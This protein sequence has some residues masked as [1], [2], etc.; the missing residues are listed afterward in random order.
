MK[1][2]AIPISDN[3][4]I[5]GFDGKVSFNV[6]TIQGGEVKEQ[7]LEFTETNDIETLPFLLHDIGI[8]DLILFQLSK[9]LL[10]D[11]STG[12]I[13]LFIGVTPQ[14]HEELIRMYLEGTLKSDTNVINKLMN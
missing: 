2:V 1:K 13:N 9:S 4:M 11:F 7:K 6:F 12:K 3:L 10:S 8:T 14:P 5:E